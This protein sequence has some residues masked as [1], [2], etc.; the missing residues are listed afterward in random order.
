M[1]GEQLIKEAAAAMGVGQLDDYKIA[2]TK[3]A[4]SLEATAAALSKILRGSELGTAASQYEEKDLAATEAQTAFRKVAKRANWA[5]FLTTCFSAVLLIVPPLVPDSKW[6]LVTLGCCGILSGALG[7][8]WL[9]EIRQ[10]NLLEAWMTG[11]AR[12]EAERLFAP[13][14][15]CASIAGALEELVRRREHD[16]APVAA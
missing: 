10:G 14:V 15:V 4:D 16:P 8:M 11:R 6:L 3:H 12:A 13:E 9:F 2:P 7:A 5:V 1:N